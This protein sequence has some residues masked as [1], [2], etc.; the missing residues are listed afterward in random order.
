MTPERVWRTIQDARRHVAA[1][2]QA[3]PAEPTT[4][5]TKTY[6]H[7]GEEGIPIQQEPEHGEEREPL[8]GQ[9]L[10]ED[11][12]DEGLAPG[13]SEIETE[14]HTH[15]ERKDPGGGSH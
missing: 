5:G 1:A 9:G 15:G 11:L 3:E 6:P 12:R 7:K 4:S 10:V 13:R 8:E 2:A 14:G